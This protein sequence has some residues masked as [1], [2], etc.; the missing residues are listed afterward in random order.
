ME[1]KLIEKSAQTPLRRME[2]LQFQKTRDEISLI[3][4]TI[5]A[6]GSNGRTPALEAAIAGYF[7]VNGLDDAEYWT[8]VSIRTGQP[9][10]SGDMVD[11][12][13]KRTSTRKKFLGIF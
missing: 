8:E 2:P 7:N 6:S 9:Y 4:R 12:L 11:K 3:C 13:T 1:V 10:L 5:I